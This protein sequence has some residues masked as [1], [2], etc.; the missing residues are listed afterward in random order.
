[1]S[2]SRE[3]VA[4]VARLANLELSEDEIARM[5]RELAAVLAYAERLGSLNTD[6]V[7]LA[8]SEQGPGT[9][10]REDA[11]EAWLDAADALR[12]APAAAGNLFRVPPVLGGE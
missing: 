3:D 7:D 12:P 11:P 2:I 9:P 10:L 6:G 5:Q 4:Y 8:G 1:M